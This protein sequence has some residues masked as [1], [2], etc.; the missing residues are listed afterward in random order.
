M[1]K[2]LESR[3]ADEWKTIFYVCHEAGVLKEVIGV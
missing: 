1:P 3:G 2:K